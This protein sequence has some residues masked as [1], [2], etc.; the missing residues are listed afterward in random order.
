MGSEKEN[1]HNSS[2]FATCSADSGAGAAA[3]GAGT[4]AGAVTAYSI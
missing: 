1:V 4:G 2:F 3:A